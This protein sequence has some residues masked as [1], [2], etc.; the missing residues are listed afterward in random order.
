MNS[1]SELDFFTTIAKS[2]SLSAA[3]RELGVTP[4]SVSKRLAQMEKRLGAALLNRTTRRLSLTAEGEIYLSNATRIL[5][6]VEALEQ[7]VSRSRA[8]PKGLI[9]VNA[10]LGFGRTYITPIVSRFVKQHPEVDVQLQLTD[11]PLNLIDESFDVGI[12]FGDPP[13]TRLIARRIAPNRR[14]LCAA[15]SYLE[16]HGIPKTPHDLVRHN[17]IVLRQNDTAYGAWHFVRDKQTE[18]VKV[19]GSLSSNDGEVTLNWAL[20][21]HGITLRAEWDIAKYLRSG[22]LQLVLEDYDAPPADI[23]A[24][25]P[26]RH[27]TSAKVRA[28]TDFL[29]DAFLGTAESAAQKSV[30]W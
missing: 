24:V 26:E 22:R 7:L 25:Y 2:G 6:E 5:A 1:I 16:R 21:G 11:H 14:M 12:R 28:F 13:D 9:R 29:V 20:A 4:P 27:T 8:E 23:F 17:C 10:P 19:R 15:P 18:T 3:A 30:V